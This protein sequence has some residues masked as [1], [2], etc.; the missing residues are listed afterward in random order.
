MDNAPLEA[1]R[2]TLK[3]ASAQA[4]AWFESQAL[5]TEREAFEQRSKKGQAPKRSVYA[6]CTKD[7]TVLYVGHSSRRIKARLTDETSPHRSKPWW[8]SWSHVRH[9]AVESE[10]S[11]LVL[12]MMLILAYTPAHNQKPAGETIE[13]LFLPESASAESPVPAAPRKPR[14]SQ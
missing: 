9:L 13:S 7:G 11:R 2:G 4:Q 1:F 12:E 3:A 8:D 5:R 6:Y 10:T 14:L